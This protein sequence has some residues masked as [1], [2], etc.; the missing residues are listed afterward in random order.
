MMY[1]LKPN[2]PTDIKHNPKPNLSK[3]LFEEDIP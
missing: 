3:G 1:N 2:L